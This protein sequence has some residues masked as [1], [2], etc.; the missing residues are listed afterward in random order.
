MFNSALHWYTRHWHHCCFICLYYKFYG[1]TLKLGKKSWGTSERLNKASNTSV[2][3]YH[4]TSQKAQKRISFLHVFWTSN[5]IA[6]IWVHSRCWVGA[7]PKHI[8][9][10]LPVSASQYTHCRGPA[11]PARSWSLCTSGQWKT[12]TALTSEQE[13]IPTVEQIINFN[14]CCTKKGS[15][16][17]WVWESRSP[18]VPGP[19]PRL[20]AGLGGH[21]PAALAPLRARTPAEPR[22]HRHR[23]LL[24]DCH[25]SR[26]S[27]L[28]F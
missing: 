15:M 22:Q 9:L 6:G 10:Y 11:Q 8:E 23:E 25:L 28:H 12:F 18:G 21:G 5:L 2:H 13:G 4:H 16:R 24:W 17:Q 26:G 19:S 3:T 27:P 20:R 14:F 1:T 7:L